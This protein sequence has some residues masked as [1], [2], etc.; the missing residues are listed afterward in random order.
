MGCFSCFDSKEDEKLNPNQHQ[1]QETHHNHHHDHNNISRLPSS[2]PSGQFLFLY[3]IF[4]IIDDLS[5]C[6]YVCTFLILI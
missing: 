3:I 5:V 1:H 2:G 4:M 6:M